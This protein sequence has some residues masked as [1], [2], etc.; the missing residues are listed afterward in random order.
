[1]RRIFLTV[2]AVLFLA[3]PARGTEDSSPPFGPGERLYYDIHWTVIRAGKAELICRDDTEM[4][5]VPARYFY[6]KARTLGWVDNFYKVRD[7][8]EAW[9]DMG[10]NHAL[11]YKKDQREGSYRKK[12]DLIFNKRT[13]QSY[14]YTKGKLQHTLDQ[15][16]DVFD[17][18]SILF[19]FRKHA[20][21]EGMRFDA[22]VSDGK[23][24]VVGKAFVEGR[25]KVET[26]IGEVDAY[27]VRLD[28]RHLSGVFKKSDDAELYV[29]FSADDRRIPVKV[30]SKVVVGSF[31]MT[32]REYYPPDRG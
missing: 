24:S 18:M 29:W 19:A 28:V 23:V 22:N 32:L 10:V 30:R 1:M 8:M 4:D 20:L 14:R 7:T 5:G 6:A 9:T 3:V 31:Y 21:Y 27:R 12:V 2:L 16:E 26:G 25:E 17:P 15:P 11:R 13:N